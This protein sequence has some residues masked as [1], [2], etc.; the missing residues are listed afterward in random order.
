MITE[1]IESISSIPKEFW[2]GI[3]SAGGA[4][5]VADFTTRRNN[6]HAL[7]MQEQKQS[8]DAKQAELDRKIALRKELYIPAIKAANQLPAILGNY[9]NPDIS[10]QDCSSAMVEVSKVMSAVL[11]IVTGETYKH[12]SEFAFHVGTSASKQGSMR[13]RI[14]FSYSRFKTLLDLYNKEIKSGEGVTEIMKNAN[15]NGADEQK[16]ENIKAQWDIHEKI[17]SDLGAQRDAA[18]IDYKELQ[19]SALHAYV[20]DMDEH[21]KLQ[22]AMLAALRSDLGVENDTATFEENRQRAM[23]AI[24]KMAEDMVAALNEGIS[25]PATAHTP[26]T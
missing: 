10:D 17:L 5:M 7:R 21:F 15:L 11:A 6:K 12:V 19:I 18:L 24:R 23:V 26:Q 20:E 4:W 25:Q 8:Y 2:T 3:L 22:N 14:K 13:I 1:I 9:M 16:W